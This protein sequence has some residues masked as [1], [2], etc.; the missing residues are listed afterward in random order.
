LAGAVDAFVAIDDEYVTTAMKM[1]AEPQGADP[2]VEA[3]E[4]GACGLGTLLAILNDADQS[5]T[6]LAAK[7]PGNANGQANAPSNGNA[8]NGSVSTPPTKV[9]A[10]KKP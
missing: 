10:K 3:G 5:T 2:A 6:A 9:K 4:S 1:W 7:Q 8:G